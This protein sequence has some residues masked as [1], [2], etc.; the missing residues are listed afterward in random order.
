MKKI[1]TI[2][3]LL[4]ISLLSAQKTS[5]MEIEQIIK[6][7]SDGIYNNG[8]SATK[9]VY[10]DGKEAVKTIYSDVKTLTPKI[11]KGVQEIAKGLKVGAESVWRI[12]VRQQL[13]WSICFLI[14]TIASLCNWFFFYKRIKPLKPSEVNFVTLKRDVIGKVANPEYNQFYAEKH[15]YRNHIK[16]QAFIDGKVGEEEY[17]APQIIDI[18]NEKY[19]Y[20]NIWHFISCVSMSGFSAYH[21]GSMMTGFLNPEY[22]AM[23]DILFVALKLK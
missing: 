21:F 17:S 10:T 15:E 19:S 14:L 8:A 9:T 4:I 2:S 13:V 6:E 3:M 22:G 16:A 20:L 11:E 12:L 18:E 7:Q 1:F 5:K 23:K